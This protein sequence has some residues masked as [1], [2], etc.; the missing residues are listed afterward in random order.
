MTHD[1]REPE[2]TDFDLLDKRLSGLFQRQS[3]SN[4]DEAAAASIWKS[5]HSELRLDVGNGP[6]AEVIGVSTKKD[7]FSYR[8]ILTLAG[9]ALFVSVGL[10]V[11]VAVKQ[12]NDGTVLSTVTQVERVMRRVRTQNE[13]PHELL[14][15]ERQIWHQLVEQ[16]ADR[17]ELVSSLAVGQARQP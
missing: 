1:Q 10:L 15:E 5:I 12:R 17:I 6:A 2:D 7:F 4:A 8:R 3:I 11:F 16:T 9:V 13:T 14:P